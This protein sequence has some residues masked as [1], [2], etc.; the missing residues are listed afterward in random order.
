MLCCLGLFVGAIVG[1]A[2]GGP[3]TLIGPAVGFGL[4][5]IGDMK[6][7]RGSRKGHGG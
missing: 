3:W 1:S 5:F 2:L 4:G 6:L 7:L